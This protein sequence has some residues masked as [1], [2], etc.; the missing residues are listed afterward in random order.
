MKIVCTADASDTDMKALPTAIK[1]FTREGTDVVRLNRSLSIDFTKFND[2]REGLLSPLGFLEESGSL[3]SLKL[4]GNWTQFLL[5]RRRAIPDFTQ[6]SCIKKLC[7]SRT[8]LSGNDVLAGVTS[9]IALEHLKLDEEELGPLQI[10]A[11]TLQNLTRL[12][13][14]G[15]TSLS[16]ITILPEALPSL[17]SL[18][19]ICKALPPGLESSIGIGSV[20]YLKEIAL[21]SEVDKNIKDAWKT[22]AKG[23]PNRPHILLIQKGAPIRQA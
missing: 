9:L 13:L 14:V 10:E 8:Y 7:L 2:N 1:A 17:V 22:A 23:H 21:D 15:E 3:S 19:L 18:H 4:H 11:G 12:C 6:I 20:K 5:S 16:G